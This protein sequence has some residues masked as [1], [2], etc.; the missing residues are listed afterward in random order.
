LAELKEKRRDWQPFEA[1]CCAFPAS[2]EQLFSAH[3]FPDMFVRTKSTGICATQQVT[4]RQAVTFRLGRSGSGWKRRTEFARVETECERAGFETT[5]PQLFKIKK[6]QVSHWLRSRETLLRH[7]LVVCALSWF[8]VCTTALNDAAWCQASATA[9][10]AGP[11]DSAAV[12]PKAAT[13]DHATADPGLQWA[14]APVRHI[15]FEGVSAE[16]LAPLPDQLAQAE[17]ASLTEDKLRTSLRQLYATGLFDMIEVAGTMDH[18]GVDLIFRGTPATF[19]GIVGVDGATGATMNTQ[20]ERA[21]QL[22]PGTRLTQAKMTRAMQQMRATLE[23][24]GYHQSKITQKITARP[25]HQLADIAFRV[26]SG[27][28]AHIGKV[29]VMGDS[30]MSLEEFRR[31]AHL[32]T[33]ANVDHETVNRALDGVLKH[34]QSQNRLEADVKLE[35]AQYD[36]VAKAVDYRFTANRGPVVIVEIDGASIEP[37][38]AKHLIPIFE[39]GSVD[40]DLLNEGNRRLRDY[41]Q[42]R[43]Y[44]DVKVDHAVQSQGN[45]QVMIRYV[46]L[47]GMRRKVERVSI[48]GNHYFDTATLTDL[49]SV[50][51]ADVLDRHGLFSQA[52]VTADVSAIETAYQS[53]GFAQV[54]V[55]PETS[56]PEAVLADTALS[57][58]PAS[59]SE[60]AARIAP[61]TLTYRISEGQQSRVGTLTIEGNDHIPTETLSQLLNTAP[62]QPLSPKTLVGDHDAL[63]TEYYERGFDQATVTVTQQP[64]PADEGKVDVVFHVDEGK[65]IFIRDVLTTGLEVTRPQTVTK[66]ITVHTGDPLNQSALA[67]TQQNLYGFALFNEVRTAVTNPAG[68]ETRK[69]VQLQTTE[70]R[71]WTLTYG[72]GFEAQ[73]GQPQNNC[74]SATAGGVACNPNGK[75]GVSPRGLAEITRNNIFGREQSA[76][77][78]GTYGLLEQ[79]IG[80]QYQVPHFE[81]DRNFGFT[82]SGGYA[83][84]EDV[85]TYVASRLEGAFRFTQNFNHPESALSRANTF[86]YELDFRRVKVAASSLQVYPAEIS[87]LSTATRVS[88]PAFTWIRDTRDVPLDAH[89]GTYTSFQDFLSDRLFGAQAEFNRID[90]SNSSYYAFDKGRFVLARNTRYGQVRTFGSG[91][92]AIVPLPERLYAGGA[93]SLRGFAQNA[94]GPR[95]P[96]TGFQIG[97]SGA[98]LNSTE[99]RLPPPTLP[100][101]GNTVSFVIFH[102]MGNVFTNARDA[103]ASFLRVRQPDSDECRVLTPPVVLTTPKYQV[104][105]PS[106]TGP[107]TSTGQ[108]GLCSFNDFSHSLGAGLRYH[109]PVGPLRFD[110]SYNLNPPIYPVNINYSI[111]ITPI[112]P[113]GPYSN[114][115]VGQ[116]PHINFF[117][118]LGQA[119]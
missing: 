11:S 101:L 71:R 23:E 96:E 68:G 45:E 105:P 40:E 111:P 74:A 15:S 42:R 88:G 87:A 22:E 113:L 32:R 12:A 110:V 28:R 92:S 7:A 53:N 62:G 72:F 115:Y 43:G 4:R 14:G 26:V 5:V 99:L 119:F 89:R 2:S 50:H 34:Y 52:L 30:G 39:E 64:D 65:Q 59:K 78:R 19:I 63:V 58:G 13:T 25:E 9:P 91:S 84:S 49:L 109:T 66:A 20:L 8:L 17:G 90:T 117:F 112:N 44:F 70:A 46:V 37:D 35:S 16:R 10:A 55:T 3:F 51:A 116:A 61:L 27:P 18:G 6:R 79:S 85:A 29:M 94:A 103:W 95:D 114:Q 83:N 1:I 118:S 75:T 57:T 24:N 33:G 56:S 69:D 54:K 36:S 104:I 48:E 60:A 82:F 93:T 107:Y 76:S 106:P 86:I 102:D 97:G 31:H 73:T 38:R 47:A 98:L 41:F 100:W 81:G 67:E 80:L 108:Q 21:C 77:L